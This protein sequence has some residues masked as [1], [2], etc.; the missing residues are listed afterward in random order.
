MSLLVQVTQNS[1]Y[2]MLW[3][4]YKMTYALQTDWIIPASWKNWTS[5]AGWTW[6]LKTQCPGPSSVFYM[7]YDL[8]KVTTSLCLHFLI[9]KM[10]SLT[11][12]GAAV[13]SKWENS[14]TVLCRL[15]GYIQAIL[16]TK[17]H[18]TAMICKAIKYSFDCHL[19]LD[20]SSQIILKI[21]YM[22]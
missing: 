6:S 19:F 17:K 11:S 7:V 5:R 14:V 15:Y 22:Y 12:L 10:V 21:K 20:L 9:C 1:K 16:I 13:K 18:A 4:E 8:N 3:N 2:S